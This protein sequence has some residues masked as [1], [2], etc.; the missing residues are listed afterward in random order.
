MSY[1]ER[2]KAFQSIMVLLM[3]IAGAS[4]TIVAQSLEEKISTKGSDYSSPAQTIDFTHSNIFGTNNEVVVGTISA[5][6]ID[7]N[8]RVLIKDSDAVTIHIFEPDGSYLKSIGREGRGPGEFSPNSTMTPILIDSDLLYVLDGSSNAAYRVSVF[9]LEDDSYQK[10]IQLMAYNRSEFEILKGYMP[11]KIIPVNS[12]TLIVAYYQMQKNP[13]MNKNMVYYVPQN[14]SGEIVSEPILTQSDVRYLSYLVK[15][16]ETLFSA[17]HAFPF[18]Q[19]PLFAVSNEGNIYLTRS[20]KFRIEVYN[21]SG[22]HLSTI[23]H[24]FQN[25]PLDIESLKEYYEETNYMSGYGEG[26]VVKML[27]QAEDLPD[28]WPSLRK[29]F[30]DDEN[31][32]WVS[33][34]IDDTDYYGW[35]IMEASGKV[36]SK[37]IWPR[38]KYIKAVRNG[39]LYTKEED[40]ETGESFVHRYKIEFGE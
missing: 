15:G 11:Q 32:L 26:V 23:Q 36:I 12:D 31:R 17:V 27:E 2:K 8:N 20:D 18:F 28:K 38:D 21:T 9:N 33:T 35:W 7:K 34:I 40:P 6:A 16:D 22:D 29:M 1:L 14:Y 13:A 39:Y 25:K 24:P 3:L 37:F 10:T 30:F 4:S 19:K 5:I